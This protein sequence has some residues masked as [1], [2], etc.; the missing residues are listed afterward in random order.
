MLFRSVILA[1]IQNSPTPF[2][3]TP[4]EIVYL[5][6]IGLSD[7]VITALVNHRGTEAQVAQQPPTQPVQSAPQDQPAPT[8]Q[9]PTYNPEPQVVYGDPPTVDYNPSAPVVQQNYF[10]SSLA[11][12]GSWINVVN[13][14][15]CW[16]PSVAVIQSDWRPYSNHGRWL[17]S[18]Q[19]WYW[20]SDYSWGW[21]PFHY[22][23]WFHHPARGWCWT[24]GSVWAPAWVSWRYTDS[25]CGW[26]PLPPGAHFRPGFGFTYYGAHVGLS[27]GFG[28]RHNAWTFVPGHRFHDREVWRHR[29]RPSEQ[30]AIYRR[31]AVINNYTYNDN[32]IINRGIGRD[33][34]P[35]MARTEPRRVAI[36]DLPEN[37]GQ[38]IRPDRLH[39][40][41][42]ET[43]VYRPNPLSGQHSMQSLE[44][45]PAR[46]IQSRTPGQVSS[47]PAGRGTSE[48]PESPTVRSRP[49]QSSVADTRPSA[50]PS[51]ETPSAPSTTGRAAP[52]R[53]WSPVTSSGRTVTPSTAAPASESPAARREPVRSTIRS[54][55]TPQR[56]AP[57]RPAASSQPAAPSVSARPSLQQPSSAG[58]LFQRPAAQ[59]QAAAPS[60]VA[61]RREPARVE[62]RP[63][64]R[65]PSATLRNSPVQ[66]PSF[67]LPQQSRPSASYSAP[68]VRPRPSYSAP[69]VQS[70]PSYSAP[71]VQSRPSY[72]APAV[73]SRPSYS[74]PA[75]QS[76]P[77]YSAPAAQ[78]RPSQSFSLPASRPAPQ[79]APAPSG[80]RSSGR[81]Q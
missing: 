15:W 25:Y 1:Y 51:R 11:P 24:P 7:V 21:A 45:R 79:A 70:R 33:R 62:S 19:G 49:G 60:A 43:V 38:R 26:A 47:S 4:D 75:V 14:G 50:S 81:R 67:S 35:G 16:Q 18:D 68:V 32:R 17:S 74:A 71:A 57:S 78:S 20:H 5:T 27:F 3:P 46:S 2:N 6:D 8:F 59:P 30:I 77:S 31:S 72:S 63:A 54:T 64:T 76:R 53:S 41:G 48:R 9:E 29:A 44:P 52:S 55:V 28:L 80:G 66:G 56:V 13:Y 73:Q 10:Y 69:A 37:P 65:A 36:R 39:R 61:P 23:R 58:N 40:A 12:Y 22:G 42:S 34:V